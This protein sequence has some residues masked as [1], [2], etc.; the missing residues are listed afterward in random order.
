M[1]DV[2]PFEHQYRCLYASIEMEKLE[3]VFYF[4]DGLPVGPFDNEEAAA[5]D[6]RR[7]FPAPK[8][9]HLRLI[10]S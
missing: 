6:A 4:V 2:K 5:R 10:S 7:M 3:G 1:D 9:P 8:T